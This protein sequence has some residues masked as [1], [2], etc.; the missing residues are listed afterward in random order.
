MTNKPIW[1][2]GLFLQPHHFQQNDRYWEYLIHLKTRANNAYLWG[3][4]Q[5]DYNIEHLSLG[6]ISITSAVGIFPDGAVFNVPHSDAAPTAFDVPNNVSDL[7]VY[8]ALPLRRQGV[9]ECSEK[10]DSV[11]SRHKAHEVEIQD[12]NT[13]EG[14][15]TMMSVGQVNLTILTNLDDLSGYTVL[16]LIKIKESQADHH[17]VLDDAFVPPFLNIN[18]QTILSHFLEEIMSLIQ[19]RADNLST[20]LIESNQSST[21]EMA[22]FMLL[23]MLNRYEPIFIHLKHQPCVHPL[24]FYETLLSLMGEIATFTHKKRRPNKNAPY[25]HDQLHE[26]FKPLMDELRR[27]LSTV[28]EQSAIS[29]PLEQKQ[30]GVW[31]ASVNDKTLLDNA[32]FVL[33]ISADVPR[34]ELQKRFPQQIKMGAIEHIKTLV[35]RALPGIELN[36]LTVAPRQIPYHTNF[37]YFTLN[38]KHAA[39][40]KMGGLALHVGGDFPNLKLEL[41]G[42]KNPSD[43]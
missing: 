8:L 18:H 12:N 32:I 15:S 26:S 43:S 17:I 27:S 4:Q 6:K 13:R 35:T 11:I 23:Q 7:Q 40:P 22:D 20:R 5:L 36:P 29:I 37:I 9:P 1:K 19:Y 14:Q 28:L 33:A 24:R 38:K 10:N 3:F 41:W 31:I 2:E 34:D 42:I 21:A 39:W 30:Y 25:S 16:P